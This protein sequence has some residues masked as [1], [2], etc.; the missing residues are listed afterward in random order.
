VN[1]ETFLRTKKAKMPQT[2]NQQSD[3]WVESFVQSRTALQAGLSP[4][5]EC[6]VGIVSYAERRKALIDAMLLA[7]QSKKVKRQK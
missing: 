1:D 2:Q 3:G 4:F 7:M 6:S 5:G